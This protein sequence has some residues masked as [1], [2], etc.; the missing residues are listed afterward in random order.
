[1]A[2]LLDGIDKLVRHETCAY[3]DVHLETIRNDGG[4]LAWAPP[5]LDVDVVLLAGD[6]GSHTHGLAWATL[7]GK[8]VERRWSKLKERL[9][10]IF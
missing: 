10:G 1:M 6:I 2:Q 5:E 3:S 9:T 8:Q 4:T 7:S